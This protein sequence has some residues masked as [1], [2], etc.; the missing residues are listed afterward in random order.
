MLFFRLLEQAVVT[1]PVTYKQVVDPAK[2]V[3]LE[4]KELSG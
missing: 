1:A 3:K 2:A 4:L